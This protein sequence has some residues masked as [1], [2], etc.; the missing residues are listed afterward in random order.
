MTKGNPPKAQGDLFGCTQLADKRLS[1]KVSNAPKDTPSKRSQNRSE[2]PGYLSVEQVAKRY[3][4]GKSTVW[5][6]V[7]KDIGFPEPIKLTKGTSRW[8]EYQLRDFELTAERKTFK[9]SPTAA[10]SEKGPAT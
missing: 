8:L 5:R 7:A 2:A 4:V 3:G 1:S 6:W 9:K 10:K